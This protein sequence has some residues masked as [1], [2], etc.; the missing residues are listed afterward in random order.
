MSRSTSVACLLIVAFSLASAH[1]DPTGDVYPAVKVENGNFVIYFYNTS[2]DTSANPSDYD[3]SGNYPVFRMVYSTTGELLGPRTPC[4]NIRSDSL[5]QASS[6]VYDKKIQLR[7]ERVLFDS[8]LLKN[9]KPSY[10][11]E[12]NGITEHRRLPWPD[13]VTINYLASVHVDDKSIAMLAT[14]GKRVLTLFHFDRAKF[15]PPE[16]AAVGQPTFIYDFPGASNVVF[17]AERYW[18]AWIRFNREKEKFETVLS[19]WKPGE[20]KSHETVLDAP[21]DWNTEISVAAIGTK[22]CVA[23][24]C[25]VTGE[26][27]GYSQIITVFKDVK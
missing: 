14:T 11:V 17:A 19:D 15:Q 16:I 8:E 3:M 24:H 9:G 18:L 10:F 22:L 20:A 25:S 27:P 1:E 7:D 4:K 6:M 12:K 23:Y 26:Y 2:R 21:A 5:W 13:D